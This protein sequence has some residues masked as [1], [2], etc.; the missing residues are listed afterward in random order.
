MAVTGL[1]N[2]VLVVV[3]TLRADHLGCYGYQRPTSPCLD[4]LAAQGTVCDA[5]FCAGLPTQPAFTTLYTGQHP[6]THGVIAHGGR[7]TLARE[8]PFLP[9]LLVTA[10]YT[11]TAVDNLA[12]LRHWFLRGYEYYIDPSVRHPL[13]LEVSAAEINARALPWLRA[14]AAEPFFLLLH[15]WDPH[16]PLCPPE[17][18]RHLFY[19]GNPTDPTNRALEAWWQEPLG[20]LAR[21]TWLRRPEGPVTDPAYIVAL[22]DQ[23]IR[24][25]DEAIGELVAEIDRLG[26]GED[27]LLLVLADHGESLTEHGIFFEHRGLY[28]PTLRVPC[29]ARWPGRIPA[30]RRLSALLQHHDLAPTILE[31]LGLE[32]PPAMDG[33]SF[34]PLLSGATT[35]GGREAIISCECTWQARWSVRTARYKFILARD[36]D[37]MGG[38]PRE[39]YD[40]WVDPAEERNL[41]DD[42]PALAAALETQLEAWIADR[43]AVLGLAEDPLVAQGASLGDLPV[44]A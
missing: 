23:E 3:D 17:R 9:Q 41:V 38:P 25:V 39:L 18:F 1:P 40:L 36:P 6:L 44:L 28:E 35:T 2:V 29:L 12:R 11:T 26:L 15:Y 31:A 4:A 33:Q 7:A 19:Q 24:A 20:A 42:E 13:L 16:W 34:W 21:E 37:R 8:A 43:L 10:G 32:I 14:H 27:T 30:G 22:Y 5:F